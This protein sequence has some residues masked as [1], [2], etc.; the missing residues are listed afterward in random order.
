MKGR[1]MWGWLVLMLLGG[2]V[3][4]EGD[5]Y[6]VR[7]MAEGAIGATQ[8]AVVERGQ[9]ATWAAGATGEALRVEQ[10]RQAMAA[11]GTQGAVDFEGTVEA[12]RVLAVEGTLGARATE[13]ARAG[14]ALVEQGRWQATGTAVVLELEGRVLEAR[15]G[16][17]LGW[18]LTGSVVALMVGCV[19]LGFWVL[20]NVFQFWAAWEDRKRSVMQAGG[21]LVVFRDVGNGVY[22][23]EVLEGRRLLVNGSLGG[24]DEVR[25]VTVSGS[26]L[27]GPMRKSDPDGSMS[28]AR[29]LLMDAVVQGWGEGDRL[30]SWRK[31]SGWSSERWQRAMGP[32]RAAGAVEVNGSEGTFVFGYACVSDL[33]Q[34]VQSGQVKLRPTLPN[35]GGEGVQGARGSTG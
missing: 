12:G 16:A 30:P 18:W 8:A 27:E 10:T 13:E 4:V 19:G 5:P 7:A 25:A 9:A 21:K 29:R 1:V 3:G 15:R 14:L 31:L 24:L 17:V 26:V 11:T 23:P 34:A 28:L 32:L 6:A 35:E 20:W 2:C 22:E 33:W